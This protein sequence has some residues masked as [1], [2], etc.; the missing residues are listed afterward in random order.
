VVAAADESAGDPSP[1]TLPFT[2]LD[3]LLVA[4]A[5]AGALGGGLLLRRR[6]AAR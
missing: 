4:V 6:L 2:G 1:A 3:L 5:G